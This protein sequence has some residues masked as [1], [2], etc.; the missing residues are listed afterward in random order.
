MSDKGESKTRAAASRELPAASRRLHPTLIADAIRKKILNGSFSPGAHLHEET[1]AAAFGTSRTPI[2]TALASLTQECLLTFAPNRGYEVRRFTIDQI[3]DA[4]DIRGALEGMAARVAAERGVSPEGL[5]QMKACLDVVDTILE[6]GRLNLAE[7][8]SWREMNV[9]FH[10]AIEREAGNAFLKEALQNMRNV[11]LV[12]NAMAQWY[13]FETVNRY[14]ADHH[15]IFDALSRRQG[16]RAEAAMR[17]HI[18]EAREFIR[19]SLES[20]QSQSAQS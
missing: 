15:R 4:Y 16:S 12:A 17:E 9:L 6:K 11:P 1:L 20:A 7:Q 13:D 3:L 2:R 14:H 8:G 19:A 18:Y 5:R 10:G